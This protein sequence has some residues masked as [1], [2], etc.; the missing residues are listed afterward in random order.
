M[1]NTITN[2]EY[3]MK[4]LNLFSACVL[5]TQAFF[6]TAV[7]S[8][9]TI[10]SSDYQNNL[11]VPIQ[12]INYVSSDTSGLGAVISASG[13]N[14]T[15]DL[16]GITF[17][18]SD[19]T[20][21]TLLDKSSSDAPQKNNSAFSS[22]TMVVQRRTSSKPWFTNWSYQSITT[23]G[24]YYYGYVQDSVGIVMAKQT[25]N[26][27][28]CSQTY[29]TTYLTDWSWAS[30]VTSTTNG[31]SGEVGVEINMTGNDVIDAYGTITTHEG[32]FPC[33]RL[34]SKSNMLFGFFTITT[35]SYEFLDQ[36]RSYARIDA[37]YTGNFPSSVTYYQQGS[38]SGISETP[39]LPNDFQLLQNYPNPFKEY[40]IL[41][42]NNP[43]G[44]QYKLS[45]IDLS[46][47]V[48]RIV[49]DITASEY[50]FE[51]G[52]LKPGLYFVELKGPIIYRGKIMIE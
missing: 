3:P 23:D 25:N 26:P 22:A 51:K 31:P 38:A 19:V 34:K 8:Q 41:I 11:N 24:L 44:Y 29:P 5:L 2:K 32:T 48:C 9:I 49:D 40:T 45:I 47:K 46:G 16:T 18:K 21:S 10:T 6:V 33:L 43:E 36:N 12:T 30:K 4:N 20:T 28:W 17:I 35:Y 52:D 27:S 7:Y 50:L 37:D 42:F 39:N 1:S 15:W 13:A 14:K